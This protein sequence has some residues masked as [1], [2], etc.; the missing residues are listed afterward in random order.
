MD[1]DGPTRPYT[2][3]NILTT[4]IL[5]IKYDTAC[6]SIQINCFIQE[7]EQC[8]SQFKINILFRDNIV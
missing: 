4:K 2:V 1:S 8:L 3:C 6:R 7:V 5:P